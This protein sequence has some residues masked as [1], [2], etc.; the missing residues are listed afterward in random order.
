[1]RARF[2]PYGCGLGFAACVLL[3]AQAW[4]GSQLVTNPFFS[5]WKGQKPLRWELAGQARVFRRLGSYDAVLRKNSCAQIDCFRQG[6]GLTQ[7]VKLAPREKFTLSAWVR[8]EGAGE[9]EFVIAT[10]SGKTLW[11]RAIASGEWR[12]LTGDFSTSDEADIVVGV[13]AAWVQSSAELSVDD[14][15]IFRVVVDDSPAQLAVPKPA[16]VMYGYADT[17]KRLWADTMRTMNILTGR[18]FDAG[19]VKQLR[20]RGVLFCCAR[21]NTA[22]DNLQTAEDFTDYWSAP[23]RDSL[24][25]RLPGGFDAIS[26]D[27]FH[28]DPDGTPGSARTAA[29]LREVR[30]RYPNRHI[31][32]WAVWKLGAGARL[33]P[34]AGKETFDEQLRAARDAADLFWLEAYITEANPQFDLFEDMARNLQ[35]RAP[36]LLPKTCLG[37]YISQSEPFIADSTAEGD[38]F[39]FLDAQFHLL[40]NSPLLRSTAGVAFW[41]FYRAEPAA[42]QQVNQLTRHYFLHNQSNYFGRGHWTQLVANPSFESDGGWDLLPGM[43]GEARVENYSAHKIPARHGSVP[44]GKRCLLMRRGQTTNQAAQTLGL[45][46][47]RTYLLSAYVLGGPVAGLSA[48]DAGSGRT[49]GRQ[50]FRDV[51]SDH[52]TRIELRFKAPHRP[53]EVRLT[54]EDQ[55]GPPGAVLFWDFVEIEKLPK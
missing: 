53:S 8:W 3:H 43:G 27:E 1:M 41:P 23:F 55:P 38:Y 31:F 29:A 42:I 6:D 20:R 7:T 39:E 47:G 36:G 35:A 12:N 11:R 51:N 44:Q 16:L 18:T 9:G 13:R 14:V 33:G 5:E 25:G 52:W 15:E 2:V 32:V 4:G 37:L 24:E 19:L 45:E 28:S 30:R 50:S 17:Q 46:A 48:A 10:S 22:G 54:L 40:R 34:Y 26:I 49:L 21:N